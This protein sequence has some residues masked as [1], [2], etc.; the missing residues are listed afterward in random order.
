M[1]EHAGGLLRVH[2]VLRRYVA[3]LL[4][5]V[6]EV[7]D[8]V[9]VQHLQHLSIRVVE[10]LHYLIRFVEVTIHSL[11]VP[12]LHLDRVHSE[13]VPEQCEVAPLEYLIQQMLLL[14]VTLNAIR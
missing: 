1:S 13:R 2:L 8:L 6:L 14:L 7:V 11:R 10:L 4:F 5:N 9:L 3:L 12:L